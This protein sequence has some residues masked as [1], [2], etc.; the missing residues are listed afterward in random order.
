MNSAVESLH[1]DLVQVDRNICSKLSFLWTHHSFPVS[2][3]S[4]SS[5]S[6]RS[7]SD[8]AEKVSRSKGKAYISKRK[9][10]LLQEIDRKQQLLEAMST[11]VSTKS[12]VTT[13]GSS[14]VP[15]IVSATCQTSI[16]TSTVSSDR[17]CNSMS[18]AANDCKVTVPP[19]HNAV[20]CSS[21]ALDI[22]VVS[23]QCSSLD[24]TV[25]EDILVHSHSTHSLSQDLISDS[26][27]KDHLDCN[28][29]QNSIHVSS[30]CT[31]S[32]SSNS[33]NSVVF[34]KCPTELSNTVISQKINEPSTGQC[35]RYPGLS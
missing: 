10:E 7:L 15:L 11:P 13:T 5:T 9:A 2:H 26:V 12:E 14:S 35:Q 34:T 32:H 27:S 23:T 21:M 20:F 25:S 31:E 16:P 18:T 29:P 17:Y 3:P 30:D 24:V 33:H 28:Y 19:D 6:S 4:Q 22:P 8:K 1:G